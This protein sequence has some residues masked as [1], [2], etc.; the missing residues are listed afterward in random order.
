MVHYAR[1]WKEDKEI[2]KTHKPSEAKSSYR[3]RKAKGDH[4]RHEATKPSINIT[5]NTESN[6]M[7]LEKCQ[8]CTKRG[9]TANHSESNCWVNP[10]SSSYKK[11]I[12]EK[13]LAYAKF[14]K[15]NSQ[16]LILDIGGDRVDLA[17]HMR[18]LRDAGLSEQECDVC[19]LE[20][21]MLASQ[22]QE[23]RQMVMKVW[24]VSD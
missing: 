4:A 20:L 24:H 2:D 15:D 7:R 1:E 19:E 23:D 8:Y 12:A 11:E 10:S 21:M 17:A 9:L 13:R 6:N 3:A 14:K 16:N 22:I 5:R 18:E